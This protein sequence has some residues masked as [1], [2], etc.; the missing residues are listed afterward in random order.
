MSGKGSIK[1]NTK[2]IFPIIKKWLYSDKDIFL[3]E[4]VVN[5]CDAITKLSKLSALGE[6]EY[7]ETPRLDVVCD[8]EAK[9]VT[10]SDNGIGMTEDEVKKY[11]NQIAFSG[12]E[13]FLEKYQDNSEQNQIIGHFGL[14][15]YS[16][17]MVARTVEIETKSYQDAPAV[18]WRCDGGTDYTI[19]DS[20]R[21]AHGTKIV[22]H[23][24]E[25]SED[26]LLAE[27][28]RSVLLK[29]CGFLPYEIYLNNEE[30]SVNDTAPLWTKPASE[31][32]DEEYTQ[33]YHKIFSDMHDPLF[34]IHLNVEF[35]FRLKGILYFPK[36]THELD[37]A[38]GKIKLYNNQVYVADN[39][40]E[41]IPEFLMLLK[42]VIDCPDVPLN[43][44]RS[45]LQN[46]GTVS[47]ISAHIT[48]KVADKLISMRKDDRESY[49]K[50]WT[51]IAPFIEY[52]CMNDEKFYEKLKPAMQAKTT[53]GDYVSLTEYAEENDKTFTYVTN[54]GQQAQYVKLLKEEGRKA[55]IFPHV[56]DVHFISFLEMREQWRF[57]RVDTLPEQTADD[58]ALIGIFQ[59]IVGGEMLK[60]T[61]SP[62]KTALPA[63]IAQEEQTRRMR[64][65]SR[66][67]GAAGM[68]EP[69]TLVL[70]S[71]S[72]IIGEIAG[73]DDEKQNLVCKQIYDLARLCNASLST[74]ELSDFIER[75]AKILEESV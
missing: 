36:L 24:G 69:L 53:D 54:E 61:T 55:L 73:M 5:G 67:F 18:L 41:V 45:M 2:N 71:E 32:T 26:F 25:D 43:V 75:S 7:A 29:Y 40:K 22:L 6:A 13:E 62:L 57:T 46:D 68:P 31:C 56:I 1:V 49:D 64:D 30:K 27:R 15:F 4:L 60:I 17:F 52:G 59:K 20:D 58:E 33:F 51:D 65:V 70:N 47:K 23:I 74:E 35:P 11:I 72:K 37:S 44:S 66:M 14:G 50:Y 16:A 3:R 21:T 38:Q 34:W 28:L 10:I 19:T 63:L 12:A 9:T 8:S 39:I 42:G 48:R